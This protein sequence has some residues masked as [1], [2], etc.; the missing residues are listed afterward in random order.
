M[1]NQASP[2]TPTD[3]TTPLISLANRGLL[4]L[5]GRDTRS[6]LQGLVTADL[7]LLVPGRALYSTLLTPQGKFLDD[8]FL[9]QPSANDD[10]LL[11]LEAAQDRLAAIA[12]RL[13]L[14]RLRADMKIAALEPAHHVYVSLARSPAGLAVNLPPQAGVWVSDPRPCSALSRGPLSGSDGGRAAAT[15]QGV[16][17]VQGDQGDQDKQAEDQLGS[18]YYC[19][20]ALAEAAPLGSP[21]HQAYE[22][23][24]IRLGLPDGDQDVERERSTLL[25]NGFDHAGAIAW[26]KGCYMGQEITARMRYR[27]LAKWDLLP[28][29]LEAGNFADFD[30]GQGDEVLLDG[31]VVGQLKSCSGNVALARLR[32]EALSEGRDR[33]MV[34]DQPL[35]LLGRLLG[36]P[37][38]PNLAVGA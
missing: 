22:Q 26:Q 37:V 8:F 7:A 14:Y 20:Q 24:R 34:K 2:F 5:S 10:D 33:I 23:Q 6:F 28:V 16:Q 12:K 38:A 3:R 35:R 17:G 11:W 15:P 19:A 29:A 18:R 30:L 9:I 4:V 31:K 21:A 32:L 36:S 25:D 13:A 1:S 27:G